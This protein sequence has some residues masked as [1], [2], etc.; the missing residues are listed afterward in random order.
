MYMVWVWLAVCVIAVVVELATPQLVSI[1]FAVGAFVCMW[2]SFIPGLPWWGQL[3][4]F[5]VL[6]CASLFLLRPLLQHYLT[7]RKSATNVDSLVG[8]QVRMLTE[9]NFDNLG[10][11]RI[12]DVVWSIKS[13]S[14]AVLPAG[15]IVEIVAVEGNK[16]IAKLSVAD[17][18]L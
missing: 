12:G 7:K 1:W 13:N 8:M 11:A 16:L 4:I 3:L 15:S 17:E 14:S 10:S 6:S 18:T 2:L 5:A 9:A